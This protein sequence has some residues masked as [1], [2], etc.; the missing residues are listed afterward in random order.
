M[1]NVQSVVFLKDKGWNIRKAETWLKNNNYKTKFYGK[2]VDKK[3][4]NQLRYRQLAPTRFKDYITKKKPNGIMF[5]VGVSA[6]DKKKM[7]KK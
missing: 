6:N 1:S 7:N 4:D 3:F 5:I 2:G